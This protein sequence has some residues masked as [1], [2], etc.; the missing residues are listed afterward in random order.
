LAESPCRAK[1]SGLPGTHAHK[2]FRSW[3]KVPQLTTPSRY[4]LILPFAPIFSKRIWSHVQVLLM[5]AILA[6][7][8]RTVT[9]VLRLT[10]LGGEKH[11]QNYHRVLNRGL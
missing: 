6:P 4:S 3:D 8:K 5:G 10:G 11:L 1:G 2:R 7:G 9:A